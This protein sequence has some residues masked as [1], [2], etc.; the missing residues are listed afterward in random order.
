V[1]VRVAR[2]GGRR[3]ALG[4]VLRPHPDTS[5]ARSARPPRLWRFVEALRICMPGRSGVVV[6]EL[7]G[8]AHELRASVFGL[9]IAFE[10]LPPETV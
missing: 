3:V 10:D 6:A 7:G 4:D 1:K 9:T 2:L 5:V 8:V